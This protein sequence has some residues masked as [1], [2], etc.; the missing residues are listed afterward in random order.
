VKT[1]KKIPAR[2]RSVLGRFYCITI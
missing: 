1:K 2:S